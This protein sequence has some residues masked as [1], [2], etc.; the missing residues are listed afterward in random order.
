MSMSL[1]SGRRKARRTF[2][3]TSSP[4]TSWEQIHKTDLRWQ[5]DLIHDLP[6]ASTY[7]D[8]I[9]GRSLPARRRLYDRSGTNGLQ[10]GKD[11]TMKKDTIMRETIYAS[12]I[13]VLLVP[14]LAL[15]QTPAPP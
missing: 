12:L 2:L 11:T 1:R 9:V 7:D 8:K 3:S 6:L 14:A 4:E 10:R 13:A 15:A 5:N